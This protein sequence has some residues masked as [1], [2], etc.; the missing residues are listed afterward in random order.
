MLVL[1]VMRYALCVLHR[2]SDKTKVSNQDQGTCQPF[3]CSR[4]QSLV[5]CG[6]LSRCTTDMCIILVL[7]LVDCGLT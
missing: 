6:A 4:F 2:A 1:Y 7:V 3:V 5:C